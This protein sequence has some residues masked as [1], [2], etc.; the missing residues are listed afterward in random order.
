MQLKPFLVYWLS[1]FAGRTPGW[2]TPEFQPN[3]LTFETEIKAKTFHEKM[4]ALAEA[5]G[6]YRGRIVIHV[7]SAID[8]LNLS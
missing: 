5:Q 6:L 8:T 4:K 1:Q 2:S 7:S 3:V